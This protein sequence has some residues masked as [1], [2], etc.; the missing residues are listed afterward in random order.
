MKNEKKVK[1]QGRKKY[2]F[3]IFIYFHAT[4]FCNLDQ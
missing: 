2:Q 1:T 4:D 3:D